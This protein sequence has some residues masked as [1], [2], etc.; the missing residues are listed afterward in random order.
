MRALNGARMDCV[1]F[2]CGRRLSGVE[3]N[4]EE[5]ARERSAKNVHLRL[6]ERSVKVVKNGFAK[7]GLETNRIKNSTRSGRTSGQLALR[8][9]V[10]LLQNDHPTLNTLQVPRDFQ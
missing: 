5:V 4:A 3:S 1:S 9:V 10:A 7:F 6:V 8:P 2:R